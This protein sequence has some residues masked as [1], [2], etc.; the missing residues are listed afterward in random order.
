[1]FPDNQVK[2]ADLAVKVQI[3]ELVGDEAAGHPDTLVEWLCGFWAAV[4]GL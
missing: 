2:R 4:P 3:A 1:L